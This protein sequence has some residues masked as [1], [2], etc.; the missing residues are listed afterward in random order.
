[1]TLRLCSDTPSSCAPAFD[2]GP[3]PNLRGSRL[4]SQAAIA[5]EYLAS[6]YL[7]GDHILQKAIDVDRELAGLRA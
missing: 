6:G 1:M 7:L 2:P 3:D 4:T 5:A